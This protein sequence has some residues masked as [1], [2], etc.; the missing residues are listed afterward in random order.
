MCI[1]TDWHHN[2]I[3]FK[4]DQKMAE[5]AGQKAVLT[6][7]EILMNSSSSLTIS[8]LAS[9]IAGRSFDSEMRNAAGGNEEGLKKLLLKYPSLFTVNENLVSLYEHEEDDRVRSQSPISNATEPSLPDVSV[10]LEAVRYFQSK[11][12]RKGDRWM[13]IASLA[14][15]LSQAS[16]EIRHVVGPQVMFQSW[17]LKHP[18][19]FEISESSVGLREDIAAVV[20]NGDSRSQN[21]YDSKFTRQKQLRNDDIWRLF[22]L[23]GN[24][25]LDED[26][27]LS[28][29]RHGNDH[30]EYAAIFYLAGLLVKHVLSVEA[31]YQLLSVSGP[32]QV[33]N[34]LNSVGV[35]KFLQDHKKI[36]TVEN[37]NVRLNT[38]REMNDEN[39]D[40]F[41]KQGIGTVYHVAKLWGII[42][43][44]DHE[45]V[46]FDRSILESDIL[47]L[48]AEYKV[49]DELNFFAFAAPKKSRAKWKAVKVWKS[50]L[51]Q[52]D[53]QTST[54]HIEN[55]NR[56][57][58][59]ISTV[60]CDPIVTGTCL[61]QLVE[62]D[63]LTAEARR[64]NDEVSSLSGSELDDEL[65]SLM[66]TDSDQG[67]I[68]QDKAEDQ[69]QRRF[70]SVACQT[71]S[72][73]DIIATS[74]YQSV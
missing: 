14:G 35:E 16:R 54:A 67:K 64:N 73:G 71:L 20:L 28:P 13:P 72:T 17:L 24:K 52:N 33:Q 34:T 29:A 9:H 46:F 62:E 70:V 57:L 63:C 68:H 18:H 43:L 55:T 39:E 7:V 5:A 19:I 3:C 26:S 1:G 44:G 49:G 65:L 74:F 51:R 23:N 36:F 30:N 41:M 56:Y 4:Q 25:D 48:Q 66:V 2:T 60:L 27:L 8:Q 12:A 15:H 42:D 69:C 53:D 32:G 58:S 6:F 11:F 10:E 61:N 40:E 31:I 37:G 50:N 45:H 21:D 59:P 47:D 38:N 22:D